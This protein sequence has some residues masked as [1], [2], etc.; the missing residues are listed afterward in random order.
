MSFPSRMLVISLGEATLDLILPWVEAGYLPTFRRF[1][2]EG[3]YGSLRS[4]LPCI[5]PQ[6]W[7]GI[8]TGTPAG[9]HGALDF[10]QRGTDGKFREIN[11]SALRQKP[12][13]KMLGDGGLS[14][15]IVNMPFTY[16]P[17]A[18]HGYMI[19]GEDAP[20]AHRSIAA[21]PGLYD[22]ITARFG[23][24]RLMDIFPGGRQKSDY[25]TLP[26]EEVRKQTEV[27]EHLEGRVLADMFEPPA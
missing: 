14:S 10:W 1:M 6:M 27:L 21:P 23:R 8:F 7:G 25:L 4:T 22:E 16:P 11:G 13:W 26:E 3:V 17:Q 20:G 12:L 24:Y 9:R 15:G 2:E 18:I 19:A 5:T